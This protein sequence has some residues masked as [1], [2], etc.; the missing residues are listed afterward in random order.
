MREYN[1][2]LAILY[3]LLFL[4]TF[5]V[6]TVWWNKYCI[7]MLTTSRKK[8]HCNKNRATLGLF[9]FLMYHLFVFSFFHVH[10]AD[11]SFN[12]MAFFFVFFL[13]CVL[14]LVQA[15]GFSGWGVWWVEPKQL[16]RL[17]ACCLPVFTRGWV[18]RAYVKWSRQ[19]ESVFSIR[20]LHFHMSVQIK[21]LR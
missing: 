5:I 12:F 16:W 13:Q 18:M 21:M 10:R 8:Q 2:L 3:L 17:C 15:I 19:L 7:H 20:H 1:K 6:W 11:S 14:A 9:V 4:C